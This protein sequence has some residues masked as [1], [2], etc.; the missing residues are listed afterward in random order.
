MDKD[1]SAW[2]TCKDT[3]AWLTCVESSAWLKVHRLVCLTHMHR[4]FS[5][6]HIHV[7]HIRV[8]LIFVQTRLLDSD[9]CLTHVHRDVCMVHV[10]SHIMSAWFTYIVIVYLTQCTDI[11]ALFNLTT[12][13]WC[14]HVSFML[15][16]Q[17]CIKRLFYVY[18]LVRVSYS[19]YW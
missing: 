4:H 13:N 12:V 7:L 15:V 6:F 17:Y 19:W 8:C 14:A 10:H 18:C 9:C 16:L 3:S 5:M 1:T 11:S 2:L